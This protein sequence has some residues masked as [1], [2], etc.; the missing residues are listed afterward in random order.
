M[1][2]LHLL[3]DNHQGLVVIGYM[4]NASKRYDVRT[5][6]VIIAA[7]HIPQFL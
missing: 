7:K 1:E 6:Y 5:C 2:L 3:R 4:R